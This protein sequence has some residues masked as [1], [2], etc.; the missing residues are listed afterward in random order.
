M[1]VYMIS[2][3][4][5]KPGQG[6]D[7]LYEAI[8]EASIYDTWMHYLDSTWFIKSNLSTKQVF[9]KLEPYIDKND[10]LL[11]MEVTNNYYGYLPNDAWDYL[12]KMF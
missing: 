2:Y 6:Y 12:K 4:L 9:A 5:N 11:V 7:K 8:K 10:H 3:D 1:A